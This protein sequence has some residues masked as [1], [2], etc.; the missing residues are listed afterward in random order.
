MKNLILISKKIIIFYKKEIQ[1]NDIA[2]FLCGGASDEQIKFRFILGNQLELRKS[3]YIYSIYYPETLFSEILLG[4]SDIDLLS[5]ENLLAK[6][7]NVVVVPLQSVG[8]FTELGAFANHPMLKDK[9]IIIIDPRYSKS[10]S[11][12]NSGP[13]KLLKNK[14]NS[15]IIYNEMKVSDIEKISYKISEAA[16]DISEKTPL[17]KD[18]TNPLSSTLLFLFLIYV[19]DPIEKNTFEKLVSSLGLNDPLEINSATIVNSLINSGNIKLQNNYYLSFVEE[20]FEN[21]LEKK[22]YNDTQVIKIKNNLSKFRIHALN[23]YY[24][25]RGLYSKGRVSP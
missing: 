15:H 5:L 7:V 2:I 22:G 9:L 8:T 21:I 1:S 11:F 18:L 6:S 12:I 23:I 24:R 10:K 25:K 3:Q 4:Y 20:G 19:F 17:K 13:I 16:R 14:T